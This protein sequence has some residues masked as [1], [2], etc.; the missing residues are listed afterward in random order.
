MLSLCL[1]LFVTLSYVLLWGIPPALLKKAFSLLRVLSSPDRRGMAWKLFSTL[2]FALATFLM[3]PLTR[4]PERLPTFEV[5][6]LLSALPFGLLFVVLVAAGQPLPKRLLLTHDPFNALG[7]GLCG[8]VA[9]G[10]W[11]VALGL[12]PVGILAAFRLLGPL[13]SFAG[14]LIFLKEK[15]SSRRLVLLLCTFLGALIVIGGDLFSGKWGLPKDFKFYLFL[16]PLC[17]ICG[18]A[19]CNLFGKRLMV[20]T[21]PAHGT[22]SL[23]A[24]NGVFFG[25][26]SLSVWQGPTPLQWVLLLGASVL[27]VAAQWSLSRALNLTQ[28]SLL[29]PISLW[30]F[31]LKALGGILLFQ[32]PFSLNLWL[33]MGLILWATAA[34]L[35]KV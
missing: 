6:F 4:G 13:V 29:V 27:E 10:C 25:L 14:A 11:Y 3:V 20:A 18:F 31:G 15:T 23:L 33:G 2:C 26:C 17:T 12:F 7:R 32:E 34:I 28:V 9:F 5:A 24:I 8:C 30:S 35:K 19:G 16:A 22:L 1:S 21:P